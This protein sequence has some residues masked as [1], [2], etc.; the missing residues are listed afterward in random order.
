MFFSGMDSHLFN[1]PSYYTVYSIYKW[2]SETHIYALGK[3][4]EFSKEKKVFQ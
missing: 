3:V 4:K 1:S 2:N